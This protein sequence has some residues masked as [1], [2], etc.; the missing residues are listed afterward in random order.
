MQCT[1]F[2][3]VELRRLAIWRKAPR[4]NDD[5]VTQLP[6]VLLESKTTVERYEPRE[7]EN[8]GCRQAAV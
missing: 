6:C 5:L 1:V 3:R 7:S 8:N 2:I 4:R